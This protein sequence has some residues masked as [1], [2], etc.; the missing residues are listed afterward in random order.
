MREILFKGKTN[1]GWVKGF[2]KK[3]GEKYFIGDR[4]RMPFDYEVLPDTICQNTRLKDKNGSEIWENDILMCHGNRNDLVKAAFGKFG[5]INMETEEVV[6]NVVGWYCEVVPTDE[7]SRHKP[8]YYSMPLTG[9]Y[10]AQCE[11]KAIGNIFDNPEL[12]Q[13]AKSERT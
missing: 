12:L 3:K 9:D 7:I 10:V 2:L 5:V 8:F 1:N 6:D 13:E 11:M 4:R